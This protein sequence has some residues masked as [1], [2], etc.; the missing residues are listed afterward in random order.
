MV[1]EQK[2]LDWQREPDESLAEAI[3]QG[4]VLLISKD[5]QQQIVDRLSQQALD[6]GAAEQQLADTTLR[7]QILTGAIDRKS[8]V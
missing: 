2:I 8:V 3:R 7:Y 4:E 6:L 5:R 1:T